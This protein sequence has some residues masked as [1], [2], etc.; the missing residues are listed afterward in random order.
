MKKRRLLYT[1]L[2]ILT[3]L[4]GLQLRAQQKT[5]TG[6]VLDA[7][8][9]PVVGGTV[10]VKG[11]NRATLTKEKGDFSVLASPEDVL[12]FTSAGYEMTEVRV[13]GGSDVKVSL[14][15]AA[16]SLNEAIVVGYGTQQ[17]KEITGSIVSLKEADLPKDVTPTINN[18]L[19]GQ[20]AGLNADT[21]SAQPGGGL[22][23]NIRGQNYP[24]YV[25]DGVPLF[26]NQAAEPAISSGGN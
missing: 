7:E 10:T 23:I 6:K 21:R 26:D 20:A 12:V 16:N 14:T 19:Q 2:G 18:M 13:R 11:Q 5:I 15:A 3:L 25:I 22:N 8:N 17:K 24:L 4:S 9:N 1:L